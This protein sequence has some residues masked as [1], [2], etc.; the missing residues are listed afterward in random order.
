MSRIQVILGWINDL[1][2]RIDSNMNKTQEKW[3]KIR[4]DLDLKLEQD[5]LY[6]FL[7]E[8]EGTHKL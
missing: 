1:V 2:L 4:Y 3:D 6:G 5:P 7:E 8:A